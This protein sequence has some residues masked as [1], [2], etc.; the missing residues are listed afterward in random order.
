MTYQQFKTVAYKY[1]YEIAIETEDARISY[2]E[3]LERA[4]ALYNSFCQMGIAGKTVAIFTN[5]CP[6]TVYAVLAASRAGARCVIMRASGPISKIKSTL[7][8]YRPSAAILHACHLERLTPALTAAD[9]RCAVTVGKAESDALPSL[10]T[11]SELMQIND[12]NVVTTPVSGG[13]VVLANDGVRWDVSER[14]AALTR[15]D[16]VYL[17]L[18]LYCGAGY[19]AL[20]ATLMSGHKC[21]ISDMPSKNLF[22]RKKISLALLYE[23]DDAF[24][25]D[26]E[27]YS[28]PNTFCI[29]SEFLY[30]E[31][32][33]EI[34]SRASGYPTRCDYKDGKV[35]IT[36]TLPQGSDI[37]SVSDS[38]LSRAIAGYCADIFYGV[39]CRKSVVFKKTV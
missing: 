4:G 17:S 9:C 14:I 1:K 37:G 23:G 38:P 2:G 8:V 21:V 15:R 16:G 5:N 28:N 31:E 36:L 29:N 6:E 33:E 24:G 25:Y 19:D 30:P 34:V 7:S 3:L 13:S 20:W 35:K 32:C 11:L 12:Y 27:Y 22:K 10:Y 39:V 26:A 18:P